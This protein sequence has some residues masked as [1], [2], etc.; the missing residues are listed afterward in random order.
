MWRDLAVNTGSEVIRMPGGNATREAAFVKIPLGGSHH[1]TNNMAEHG[2]VASNLKEKGGNG[3][4][5]H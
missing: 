4:R 1:A 3:E 5:L 2:T